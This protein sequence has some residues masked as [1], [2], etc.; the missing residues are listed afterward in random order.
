M[1]GS[2]VIRVT[3]EQLQGLSGQVARSSAS[4]E[5]Q[6]GGLAQ[7][8][9]PLGTDWAG[10]AQAQFQQLWNEWQTS[11]RQLREA[12]EGIGRLLD[13]AGRAYAS[14]EQQI[15]STFRG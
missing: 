4:I 15:A 3:P 12:L 5:Q 10:Q 8:L 7:S 9:A 6:L 14:A 2:G 11:S 13:N 1:V